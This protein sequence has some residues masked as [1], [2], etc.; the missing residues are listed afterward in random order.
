MVVLAISSSSHIVG[1]VVV[2]VI[3]IIVVTV[4]V[5]TMII[6]II[7]VTVIVVT[8][9]VVIITV[10]HTFR[11]REEMLAKFAEDKRLEQMNEARRRRYTGTGSQKEKG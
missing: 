9:I 3:V 8:V 11:F 6:V 5:V 7:V 4:I 10:V 2:I 1:K